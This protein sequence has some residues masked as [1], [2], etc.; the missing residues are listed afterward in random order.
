MRVIC[1]L[2]AVNLL[3]HYG[4]DPLEADSRGWTPLHIAVERD[5]IFIARYLLSLGVPVPSDLLVTLDCLGLRVLQWNT[6]PMVHLLVQNGYNALAQTDDGDSILHIALE[7]S[8]D[9]DQTLEVVKLLVDYG[10]DPL[11]ANHRGDTPIHI[12]VEQGHISTARYLLTLGAYLPPD[13]LVSFKLGRV[14][15]RW[16]TA[17]MMR[18]LVENGANVLAHASDGDSVL[19][20]AL[21]SSQIDDKAVEMVKVLVDYGCDPLEAN[22]HGNI[23]LHIAVKHGH[24]I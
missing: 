14:F 11:R 5:H 15:S 2:R 8:F 4:C 18:F 7:N 21:Q 19:H 6:A 1:I 22:P 12:A 24:D 20:I 16:S 23:P 13:L 17:P 10:C 9:D 3:V